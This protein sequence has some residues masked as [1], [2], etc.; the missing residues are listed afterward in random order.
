MIDFWTLWCINCINTHKD[1]NKLYA[2]FK[3]DWFEI[4]GLHAPEFAYERKIEN[5]RAAVEE[6]EI[7]FPVATD[8][9]F[10]TWKVYN[11]RYWPAFYII[12]AQGN[13]RY[14]HFWEWGYEEKR[15]VIQELL[16][17]IR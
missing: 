10:A 5:V 12:D 4:L 16:R 13:V 7:K 15:E 2:E 8:N 14:T 6:F 9:D 11:N 17:E 1:T 3:N